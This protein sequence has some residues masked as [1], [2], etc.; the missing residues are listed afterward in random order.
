[1]TQQTPVP[2]RPSRTQQLVLA[3]MAGIGACMGIGLLG[4]VEQ[5]NPELA[6]LMAPF[7]ATAVLIFAL[8]N[9]PLAQ[10]VNVIFGHLITASIGLVFVHFADVTPVTI[11]VASGLAV[12]AMVLTNTIH[13]P[14]GA[15][16]ILIMLTTQ[17]WEF[18]IAPV[19]I[20]AVV[21]VLT[22]KLMQRICCRFVGCFDKP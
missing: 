14:A 20:G 7:G 11:G 8:P 3:V 16:P 15:N 21:L 9:S 2:L 5:S 1:M 4:L 17:S 10:P 19:M 13:P 6:V 12:A 18:L 22:G